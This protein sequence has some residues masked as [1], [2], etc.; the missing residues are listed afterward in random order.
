MLKFDTLLFKLLYFCIKL[1]NFDKK[2]SLLIQGIIAF[3][4]IIKKF[5]SIIFLYMYY[6]KQKF[7]EI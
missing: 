2:K 7:G 6:T 5:L 3:N 4:I 1:K